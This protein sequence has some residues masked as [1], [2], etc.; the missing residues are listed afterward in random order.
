MPGRIRDLQG[1]DHDESRIV[2]TSQEVADVAAD[3]LIERDEA[4]TEGAGDVRAQEDEDE[5]AAF[6]HE[7]V[8]Q[9]DAGQ[10]RNGDEGAIGNLHEC[11]HERTEAETFDDNGAK[12]GNA[13][14]RDV[15]CS[16]VSN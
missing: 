16:Y 14:V 9:V 2:W 13:A 8:V 6:I 15:A 3:L 10:D 7:F 12:I 1:Q 5:E 4:Q 11:R